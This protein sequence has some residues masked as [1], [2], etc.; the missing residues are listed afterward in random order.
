MPASPTAGGNAGAD[1]RSG[2]EGGLAAGIRADLASHFAWPSSLLS[3]SRPLYDLG[4]VMDLDKLTD[5]AAAVNTDKELSF[6]V[7]SKEYLQTGLNW[8]NAMR[9]IRLSNFVIL[10]GDSVTANLFDQRG[11]PNVLTVID[12]SGF[13]PTFVSTTGFSAK[14]LAV[15]AFKFPVARFL[16]ESGYHVVLSDADAVWLHDAMPYLRGADVAFQRIAYHPR[17]ISGLWGFAACGGFISFRGG[18]KTIAYLDRCIEEN[19]SLFCDQVA[20][21]L[22]LVGGHPLW[23]CE[24]PDWRLPGDGDP[25]DMAEREAAFV[26]FA[27][28]PIEGELQ[29]GGVRLLALPHDKFWRHERVSTRLSDMIVCHPNSPKDDLQKMAVLDAMGIRFDQGSSD[30]S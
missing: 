18:P 21:N 10:A 30:P 2:Q 8:V 27:K 5:V 6:A 4:S 14:G 28:Y 7:V 16:A 13:D 19:R 12:E 1:P 29:D 24:H 17:S 23:H 3:A 22:A 20:M 15:S 25:H 26:K 9:R 11:I